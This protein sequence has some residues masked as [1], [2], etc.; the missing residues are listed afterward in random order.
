MQ[1]QVVFWIVFVACCTLISPAM[2]KLELPSLIADHMVLQQGI[3][4]PVW[5]K[6][7]PGQTITVTIAD[8]SVSTKAGNNGKWKA[9][10]KE[11]PVGGPYELVI[12]GSESVTIKDVLVGEVWVASG[13]SNMELP[14]NNTLDA[15]KEVPKAHQNQIRWFVQERALSSKPLE[16]PKGT[17]KV[18]TPETAKDFSAAAYYFSKNIHQS[19]HVPVGILG[20]YWGGTWIESWIPRETFKNDP[21]I[22]S[23]LDQWDSLSASEKKERGGLQDV[24]LEIKDFHF[25]PKSPA[26]EP[27]NVLLGPN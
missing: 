27:L 14:L 9:A 22:E 18:C 7:K 24:E 15:K 17:W 10:L 21:K 8:Q 6:D 3:P 4:V 5:E 13:Q 25:I 1:K 26:L 23:A 12:S 16:D 2:A 19:L 20:T 11:L